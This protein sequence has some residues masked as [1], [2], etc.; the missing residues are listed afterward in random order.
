MKKLLFVFILMGLISGAT[1]GEELKNEKYSSDEIV[2]KF[3]QSGEKQLDNLKYEIKEVKPLFKDF[4]KNRQKIKI[5]SQ[6][7]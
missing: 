5:I 1:L 3:K 6:K 4:K 7:K 2:V